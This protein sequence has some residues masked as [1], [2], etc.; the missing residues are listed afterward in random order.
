MPSVR[1]KLFSPGERKGYASPKVEPSAVK[2]A[3]LNH[4]EFAA[5]AAKVAKVF[6]GWRATHL[7]RLKS[8]KIGDKPKLLIEE[9]AENLLA[10][11]AKVPLIDKYDIYQHL[12]TY[13][14]ETMQDD[15]YIIAQEGWRAARQIREL[16]KNAEG[17]FTETPDIA[18]GKRKLKAELIPPA[19]IVARFFAEGQTDLEA[20]EAKAEKSAR[21][22]EEMDEEQGGEDGLLSEAKTEKGKLTAKS[23]KER[24]KEIKGDKTA[25]DERAALDA[26]LKLIEQEKEASDAAKAAKAAL[27]T[28]V[29]KRYAKLTDAEIKLLVVEDKWLTALIDDVKS[30]LDRISQG[31]TG[32]VKLLTERYASPL[33]K[34]AADADDLSAKVD[35]HL[36]RMGFAA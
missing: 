22:I 10:R 13:W 15:A 32:R 20:L 1:S 35:A 9:I 6:A 31:L 26:C 4:P 5:Y 24:L 8:L 34:L 29:V 3:I 33:P 25:D 21:A 11:F 12:M 16:V 27:D 23:V 2:P 19:L 17:K 7:E 36:K 28:Q 14:A 30:E 18:V